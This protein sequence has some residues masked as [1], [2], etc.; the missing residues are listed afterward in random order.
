MI[1]AHP[2]CQ[3]REVSSGAMEISRRMCRQLYIEHITQA[4]P[5]AHTRLITGLDEFLERDQDR[6]LFDLPPWPTNACQLLRWP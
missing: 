4:D 1:S 2:A 3:T 6:A 5:T